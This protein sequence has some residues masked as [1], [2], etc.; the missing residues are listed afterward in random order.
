MQKVALISTDPA[1]S[2]GDAID[3]DFSGGDLID[4]PLIGV[5]GATGE[6]SLSVMEIDPSNALGQFKGVVN[7]LIG[8]T[9]E[10]SSQG[11][12]DLKATLQDLEGILEDLEGILGGS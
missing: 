9:G 12:N 4:C 1:H 8:K 7:K 5:P 6:G 11:G 3:M 2:L 10:T